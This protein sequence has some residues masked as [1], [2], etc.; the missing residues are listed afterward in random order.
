MGKLNT[1]QTELDGIAAGYD[2]KWTY[3]VTDLQSG[4]RI[5][6]DEDDVM[7]TASL[8]KVPILVALYRAAH[9]GRFALS[10][11]IQNRE[12]QKVL[13]SG[14]LIHL[15][16]G[17]DMTVRDA[18]VLMIIISDNVATNMCIDLVGIDSINQA[19]RDL[20]LRETTLF[21][22]LGD[23]SAGLD[24]RKM[25][26]STAGE[27]NRL[28]ELIARHEVV[29]P[30][31]SEDILRIMRRQ[32][33]RHELTRKLPWNELNHLPDH[34]INWVAEKGG[35]FLN[36]IRASGAVFSGSRGSFVMASFCEG[37]TSESTGRD[38]RANV[39]T[40]EAGY[41]AWRA[42]AAPD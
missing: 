12:D 10:D 35:A 24:A 21:Q 8:I 17:V 33:Y 11:R 32:D 23:R 34:H 6:H 19:M 37:G 30:E 16:P 41:A 2:G 18:A 4:E 22:R 9:E 3:A 7:P 29:S 25:S 1:L 20:G 14:V 36:G 39:L 15:A 40:G 31:S 13:G 5:G 38:H 42:L 27:M 26:V 28:L